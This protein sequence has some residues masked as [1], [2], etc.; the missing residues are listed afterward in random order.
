MRGISVSEL[1]P[2]PWFLEA[3]RARQLDIHD[4]GRHGLA[5]AVGLSGM[6]LGSEG[7]TA[8]GVVAAS[9]GREIQ[10]QIS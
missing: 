8:R 9:C 10:Q 3:A 5:F 6:A 7:F 1:G 2:A 4:R